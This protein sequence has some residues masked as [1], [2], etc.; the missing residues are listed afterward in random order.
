MNIMAWGVRGS[1]RPYGTRK[2][3][4]DAIPGLRYAP[5]GAIFV[6]S[7]REEFKWVG[8]IR[9][10]GLS[11]HRIR[12]DDDFEVHLG[13]IERHPVKTRLTERPE[14][15]AYCSAN[16]QIKVDAFPRGLKPGGLLAASGA[17]EAAPFQASSEQG[18]KPRS[19]TGATSGMAEAAPFQNMS[20]TKQEIKQSNATQK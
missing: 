12:D 6:P 4:W 10:T 13:Y 2:R 14:Q 16:G 20:S 11:D 7:L 15:Y 19:L 5:S 1:P 9:V 3:D 18:L 8:D 17:A